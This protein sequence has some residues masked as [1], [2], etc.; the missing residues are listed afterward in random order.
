MYM[1]VGATF[2]HIGLDKFRLDKQEL[3]IEHHKIDYEILPNSFEFNSYHIVFI[4]ITLSV[5]FF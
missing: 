2:L 1:F 4:L 3:K 5:A